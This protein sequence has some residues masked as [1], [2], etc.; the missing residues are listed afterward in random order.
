VRREVERGIE[1]K[2]LLYGELN[3]NDDL[4]KEIIQALVTNANGM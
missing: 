1:R 3:L 2:E 4:I